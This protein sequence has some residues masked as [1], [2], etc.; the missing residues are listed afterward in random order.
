MN[1]TERAF[2]GIIVCRQ[3]RRTWAFPHEVAALLAA[4]CAGLSVLQLFGGHS[5]FGV[6]LDADRATRPDVIGNSFFPPF[7]C[8]SFDVVICDPP[9]AMTD[10]NGA[11]VN[12]VGVAG[13]LARQWV[14]WF[15][16]DQMGTGFHGLR[17]TK[18]WVV[19]TSPRAPLRYLVQMRRLRHPSGCRPRPRKGE[20]QFAPAIRKYDW[21]SHIQQPN[22]AFGDSVGTPQL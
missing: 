11:W 15:S 12:C 16:V 13:C 8:A 14:W 20:K 4:E 7:G 1:A 10:S 3:Y 21:R 18:W 19:Q 22:F 5:G 2:Q 9:Y 6:R 17:A